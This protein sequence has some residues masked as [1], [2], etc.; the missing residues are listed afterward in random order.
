[1]SVF[2]DAKLYRYL[3]LLST[4]QLAELKKHHARLRHQVDARTSEID[5]TVKRLYEFHGG[6][7]ATTSKINS[8]VDDMTSD[9][10][11]PRTDDVPSIQRGQQQFVVSD[12]QFLPFLRFVRAV[13]LV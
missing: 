6:L 4:S 9:L 1:M 3:M 8:L 10:S 2:S 11:Q 13:N 12:V 5:S 7:Q